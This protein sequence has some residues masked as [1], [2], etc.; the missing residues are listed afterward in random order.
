MGEICF[1]FLL[2]LY[3]NRGLFFKYFSLIDL[4][5]GDLIFEFECIMYCLIK[6]LKFLN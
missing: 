3:N 5:G 1:L 6:R 2:L 4:C